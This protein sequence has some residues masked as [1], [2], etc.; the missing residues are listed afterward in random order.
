MRQLYSTS[1]RVGL[2]NRRFSFASVP[3]SFS[4]LH[5]AKSRIAQPGNCVCAVVL[6]ALEIH[7]DIQ[8]RAKGVSL[9]MTDHGCRGFDRTVKRNQAADC[10]RAE[11][12]PGAAHLGITAAQVLGHLGPVVVVYCLQVQ[13]LLVLLPRPGHLQRQIRVQL[14]AR[15]H[16]SSG[17][18]SCSSV[19]GKICLLKYLQDETCWQQTALAKLRQLHIVKLHASRVILPQGIRQ[20]SPGRCA[21]TQGCGMCHHLTAGAVGQAHRSQWPL[22][23]WSLRPGS[24]RAMSA[25]ETSCPLARARPMSV[26]SFSSSSSVQGTRLFTSGFTCMPAAFLIQQ[27]LKS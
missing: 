16:T 11:H 19:A 24:L 27:Q 7:A 12:T 26:R 18:V 23:C 10:V 21:W 15:G 4:N 2:P 8:R 22:T 9:P 17:G 25:Q 5:I 3:L 13:Q 6:W 14:P 1:A 20:W